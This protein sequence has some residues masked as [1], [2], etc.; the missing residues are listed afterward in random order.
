MVCAPRWWWLAWRGD[1]EAG[2]QAPCRR[3]GRQAPCRRCPD[4]HRIPCRLI[5]PHQTPRLLVCCAAALQ[6]V[7]IT[8]ADALGAPEAASGAGLSLGAFFQRQPTHPAASSGLSGHRADVYALRDRAGVLAQL[9]APPLVLHVAEAEHTR[10]PFEASSCRWQAGLSD[11]QLQQL[12]QLPCGGTAAAGAVL[13]RC[14]C[15]CRCTS[16][17]RRCLLPPGS[18]RCCCYLRRCCRFC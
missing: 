15:F 9:G 12:Q 10:F 17:R 1:A 13:L 7:V 14:P 4:A 5:G 16:L 8:A 11:M 6:E 3:G 18:C 2:G